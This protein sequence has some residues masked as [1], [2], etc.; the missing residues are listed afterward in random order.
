[1]NTVLSSLEGGRRVRLVVKKRYLERKM[2]VQLALCTE[3]V[4]FVRP[5]LDEGSGEPE[6]CLR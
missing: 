3:R 6:S 2:Q 1:M 4:A 5:L